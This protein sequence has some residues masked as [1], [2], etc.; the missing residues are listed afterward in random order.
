MS[1]SYKAF[2]A[3][4]ESVVAA[5]KRHPRAKVV[6]FQV[7]KPATDARIKAVQPTYAEDG[8]TVRNRYSDDP[9]VLPVA[10][11]DMARVAD[12]I[13]LQW[14]MLTDKKDAVEG[15]VSIPTLAWL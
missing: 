9:A 15:M 3:D 1:Q 4:L 10:L 6:R 11:L 7:G 13:N 2:V 8:D 14:R 12:G 5:L